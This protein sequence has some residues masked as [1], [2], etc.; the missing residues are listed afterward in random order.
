MNE[1]QRRKHLLIETERKKREL[2][3]GME[4]EAPHATLKQQQQQSTGTPSNVLVNQAAQGKAYMTK[5]RQGIPPTLLSLTSRAPQPEPVARNQGT[6][7]GSQ[8]GRS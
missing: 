6:A 5:Y 7:P 3:I 4:T 8:K 1:Y 2:S